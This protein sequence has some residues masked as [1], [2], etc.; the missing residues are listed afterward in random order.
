MIGSRQHLPSNSPEPSRRRSLLRRVVTTLVVLAVLLAMLA[1]AFVVLLHHRMKAT[2]AQVDGTVHLQGLHGQVAV[3]RDAHG[4]PHIVANDMHDLL[5]AQGYVMASDRLWQMDMARRLPEGDAAEVLGSGLVERDRME[6][7]LGLRDVAARMDKAMSSADRGNMQSFADGVNSFIARN[8]LPAEFLLLHY[9]PRRWEPADSLVI[10]ISMSQ[11]LDQRWPQKLRREQVLA[12]LNSHGQGNLASDLYPVGSWRDHPPVP[13]QPA[14]SDPQIF[15]QIPLD[16]SQRGANT[17]PVLPQRD[18]KVLMALGRD[19]GS[20]CPACVPGSNEWAVSGAHTKSGKPLL[21]NDMH[22]EHQIPDA[23]YEDDL[24]AGTFH[25]AGVSI[26]GLPFVVAGHNDHIAWGFTA[27]SGDTQDVYVEQTNRLGDYHVLHADG[28]GS[29]APLQHEHEVIHVRGAKDVQ[30]D[31]LRTDHGP[32]ITPLLPGERR[33]LSL[34]WSLYDSRAAGLPLISL[35]SAVDWNSFRAALSTWW[36]PTLNVAYA[37]NS[38]HIGYQ[39]VGLIPIRSGGLQ[40][41]PITPKASEPTPQLPLEGSSVPGAPAPTASVPAA[42]GQA[43]AQVAAIAPPPP[44]TVAGEWTGFIPFD[45]MPSVLDPEG[46]IVATANARVSPDGA[47]YQ[48]TLDWEDPYRNERLWKWLG[49]HKSLTPADMLQLQTDLHS[50]SDQGV[51]QR[52][53]YAIDHTKSS[54]ARTHAAADLLRSWNGDVSTDSAAVAILKA[55]MDRFWPAVLGAKIGDGWKLYDWSS[56]NFAREQLITRQPNGWLPP[57]NRNWSEFLAS[58]VTQ[59]IADGPKN[60]ATWRFGQ[61]QTIA[62]HHPLWGAVPTFRKHSTVGPL[63]L[64]GDFSTVAQVNGGVGPSQRFTADLS[65]LDHSTENIF[66]GESGNPMSPYYRDQWPFWYG[67]HT[68][69]LPY[70]AAAVQGETKHT[71]NLAP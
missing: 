45:T 62:V 54:P 49:T 42:A 40:F 12:L 61:L 25:A 52:L 71:L 37:D 48:I 20:P 68:F 29:W 67:G 55:T 69:T 46:G 53:A 57:N 47:P 16:P 23:W 8:A 39:A 43:A 32:V 63:P 19:T 66:V 4:V 41:N 1:A 17:P 44:P 7:I 36:G 58:L 13:S 24:Q 30:L 34:K 18:Q 10:A 51:A 15:Q 14:I 31:I 59:A 3:R 27:L 26:A 35:D 22:L 9:S 33:T 38:G 21:S 64:G 28:T 56:S 2:V 65:N 5:F 50:E 11:T 6:R 60:L 70:S